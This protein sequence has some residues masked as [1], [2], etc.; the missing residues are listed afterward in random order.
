MKKINKNEILRV[1]AN[2]FAEKSQKLSSVLEIAIV[3]SV[4]GN[5]P[6]PNDLDLAIIVHNLDEIE[7]IAKYARQ[8]SKHYHAWEVFLFN[9]VLM[10]LGRVCHRRECPVRSIDCS[11]PGCGQPHHLRVYPDFEYDEKMFFKS[12]IDMLW[13]SFNV[14]RFLARKCELGIGESRKYPMQED[15]EI[16]CIIC[17]KTF[18]FTSSEQK[19]YQK[20][21]LS[22][23]KRC[24]DCKELIKMEES[25]Q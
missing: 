3:G 18:L 21:G 25:E 4:A 11:V 24:H 15:I 19:W 6:H 12:P 13:T 2:E 23:P 5:D 22:R 17:G 1:A 16:K 14:S 9:E 10:L 20:H 7:F 8:M